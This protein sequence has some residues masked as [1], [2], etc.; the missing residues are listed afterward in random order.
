M[1]LLSC[2][3]TF[4]YGNILLKGGAFMNSQLILTIIPPLLAGITTYYT[5]KKNIFSPLKLEVSRNRLY[6]VYLPLFKF[7]E[8]HLYKTAEEE[9]LKSLINI[10]EKIKETHYELIDS[11][12]LNEMYILKNTLTSNKYDD[13]HFQ[14]L[15]KTID[16]NFE[17]TRKALFLPTRKFDYRLNTRQFS[18]S[19]QNIL[20]MI[21][22]SILKMIPLLLAGIAFLILIGIF[23][24]IGSF[25]LNL[26]P[27]LQL[28]M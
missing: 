23:N 28:S 21:T 12:L 17:K 27:K 3:P 4:I 22:D 5:V 2:P 7:I 15:C 19:F 6:N 1:L 8:P 10:F 25:I 16:K 9:T 11:E 20:N 13:I 24:V 18:K 26:M 14:S